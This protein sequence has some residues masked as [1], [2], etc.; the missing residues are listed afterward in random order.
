M[1]SWGFLSLWLTNRH[2]KVNDGLVA[3]PNVG[4]NVR[5]AAWDQGID[6][7]MQTVSKVFDVIYQR[8]LVTYVKI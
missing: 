8:F 7:V 2:L 3:V 1:V 6:K 5:G 4:A